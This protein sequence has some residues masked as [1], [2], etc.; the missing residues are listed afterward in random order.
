MLQH[1]SVRKA[2][3]T[4]ISISAFTARDLESRQIESAGDLDE[5]TPGLVF[6]TSAPSSGSNSAATIFIRGVGQIDFVPTTDPGVGLYVDDVYYAR[7]VGAALDFMDLERIEVL[8]GPQGTLFGRNT[9]GGAI[10]IIPK[11]PSDE[12]GGSL[13]MTVGS[14]S[15]IDVQGSLDLP[16]SDVL[17]SKLSFSDRRRDG[18]VTRL[19]DG[20]KTGDDNATSTRLALHWDVADNV[21]AKFSADYTRERENGAPLVLLKTNEGPPG[22]DPDFPNGGGFARFVN[23]PPPP[24]PAAALVN[25][26]PCDQPRPV[27]AVV[28]CYGDHWV[29]DEFTTNATLPVMSNLDYWGVSSKILWDINEDITFKSVT[30]YRDLESAFQR[31]PDGSPLTV[32]H[33]I[34]QFDQNQFSQEFQLL[35]NSFGNFSITRGEC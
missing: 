34:D 24:I 13:Q 17:R 9:I 8:K 25:G 30:A 23:N 2:Y 26:R 10:N 5:I 35:G 20:V 27:A 31:D 4:Y 16:I 3:R 29:V 19:S 18:Y 1:V 28:G 15:R 11:A 21:R 22:S 6:D 33:T 12:F 7:A 14:D 32:F